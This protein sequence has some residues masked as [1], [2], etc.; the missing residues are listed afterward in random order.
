MWS[1][2]ADDDINLAES[3]NNISKTI[4]TTTRKRHFKGDIIDGDFITFN[5]F[6]HAI[7]TLKDLSWKQSAIRNIDLATMIDDPISPFSERTKDYLRDELMDK[8]TGT[9]PLR[10]LLN[11]INNH[12]SDA[13]T[14]L[15]ELICESPEPNIDNKST[16][17]YSPIKN[18]IKENFK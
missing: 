6:I 11:D 3:I 17:K 2:Q 16:L 8:T 13:L 5:G 10:S 15:L 7:T 9:I 1:N 14:A 4:V 18:L 12:P